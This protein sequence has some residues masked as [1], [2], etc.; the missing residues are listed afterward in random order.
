[1]KIEELLERKRGAPVESISADATLSGFAKKLINLKLGALVVLEASGKL[2]GI[3]SERDLLDV[4]AHH[5]TEAFE[6]PVSDVMTKD[7][8]TCTAQDSVADVLFAMNDKSIRH[9]PVVEGE[10]LVGMISIREL[11]T[12][13]DVLQKE[14]N[15]DFLTQLSN[16]RVFL[17]WGVKSSQFYSQRQ[18][19]MV[20]ELLV[21]VCLK[22]C[23]DRS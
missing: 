18:I 7:I 4:F 6:W 5:N 12:A 9:M 21:N 20:R 15:T 11:T 8:I 22:A 3:I 19:R 2:A 16:R 13:Y 1:M 23:G 14:A 17:V 10:T